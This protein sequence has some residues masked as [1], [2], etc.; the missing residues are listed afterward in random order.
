M[1]GAI[2]TSSSERGRSLDAEINLVPFIDLLSMCI[3]FL[4]MTAIWV[5]ISSIPVKQILGTE[6]SAVTSEA[7]DLQIRAE[8]DHSL[9]VQLEKGG[10]PVQAF[11]L[12]AGT[13]EKNLASLANYLGQLITQIPQNGKAGEAPNITARVIPLN[14]NYGDLVQVLD[15]L[16][17]YGVA[18]F[19]VVP[20]KSG[21]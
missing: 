20:S 15:T 21:P 1:A 18:Q 12:N 10:R 9:A 4:L 13:H 7:L 6:G 14:L 2:G 17:G 19:A 5:E 8:N 11:T 16:R 3:C